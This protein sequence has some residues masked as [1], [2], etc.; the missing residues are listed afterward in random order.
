MG[1]FFDQENIDEKT[2]AFALFNDLADTTKAAGYKPYRLGINSMD[3]FLEEVPEL[4]T[5]F[6]K[7]KSVVDPTNVLAPGKYVNRNS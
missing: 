3:K 7:I 6:A 5:F 2:R 4:G 1:I